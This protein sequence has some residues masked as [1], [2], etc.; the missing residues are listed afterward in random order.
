MSDKIDILGLKFTVEGAKAVQDA[1]LNIANLVKTAAD[2]FSKV[3]ASVKKSHTSIFKRS[4]NN[5]L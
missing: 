4:N 1:L 3:D 5:S 2:S